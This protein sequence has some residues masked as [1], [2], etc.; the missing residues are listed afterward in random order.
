MI[1][2]TVQQKEAKEKKT[3]NIYEKLAKVLQWLAAHKTILHVTLL[4]IHIYKFI[5]ALSSSLTIITVTLL[6]NWQSLSPNDK[7]IIL[8]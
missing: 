5:F 3:Q 6:A 8:Q 4:I 7:A 1:T 2:L